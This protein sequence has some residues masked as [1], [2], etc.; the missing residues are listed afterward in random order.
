MKTSNG[1][2]ATLVRDLPFNG[3]AEQK[4]WKVT[5][6]VKYSHYDDDSNQ[7][8]VETSY[9]VTSATVA[10]FSGPETYIFPAN[11][12]SDIL[13][14]MELSGSYRGGLDHDKAINGLADSEVY[15]W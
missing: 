12:N 15:E 10:I 5:P 4:L 13:D 6:A 2:E 9:V 11:E 3:V 14:W 7:T 1:F 8:L